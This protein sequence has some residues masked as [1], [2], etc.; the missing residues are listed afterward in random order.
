MA[1]ALMLML[2]QFARTWG[3]PNLSHFCCKTETYLR[4]AGIEYD[5]KTTL[6]LFA[7]KGKLPYI[8]DGDLK[9]AD[10]RFII[11]HF[12]TRYKD[13]DQDLTSAEAALSLAMQRLIEEHLF[14]VTMYSRWQ[15]TDANWQVNKKAIFGV[16]PPGIRDVVASIYRYKIN[17]QIYG[18]GTGRHKPNEIFELGMLDVDALAACLGEKRYFLGDQPTTLDASAFGFLINTLGCPIESPLKEHALSKDNLRNY[19]DRIKAEYYPDL[20]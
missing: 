11:R 2:Y 4:M 5:I 14:W 8:E 15:Y 12:K 6:P 13:L 16:L 9:L 10:S 17:Q 1:E 19:V 7:P 20:Q 3:N 18:H